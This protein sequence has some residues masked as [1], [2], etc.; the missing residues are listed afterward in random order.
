MPPPNTKNIIIGSGLA[1][2]MLAKEFRKLDVSSSLTIITA[3]DGRFYSKP[4]LS[5]ALTQ[6]KTADQLPLFSAEAMAEQLN[7]K[8]ITHTIVE[9]IDAQNQKIYFNNDA[10]EYDQLILACGAETINPSLQGDGVKSLFVVNDLEQYAQF[11]EAI[12]HHRDVAILGSGLV[13]C[14]FAQDLIHNG[15]SVNMVSLDNYP[16]QKL[17]PELIGRALQ[18][19]FDQQGV[20]WYL[21]NPAKAI[22]RSKKGFE[23]VL[24]NGERLTASVVLSAVGL[25]PAVGLAKAAGLEVQNGIVVNEYL[26]T[27]VPT[28]YALG[29]CAE[30]NS[31]VRMYVAPLLH[32]ARLL[33]KTLTGEPTVVD[34]PCMPVV[35]KTPSCPV[36][37]AP[38]LTQEKGGWVIEGD[39]PNL[40]ALFYDQEKRLKGFALSGTCVADKLLLVKNLEK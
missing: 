4:L 35:V 14:E 10:L 5:T 39:A 18:Q 21:S 15:F 3:N 34:F 32:S 1:G 38:P 22:L 25:K 30:V 13:G 17:A 40:K 23:I 16:L 20:H 24:Q 26:Q 2:Y 12:K 28:I 29:D 33:A 6:H 27:S 9:K 37:S 7:A 8:I 11:R 19:S 36:V 31:H